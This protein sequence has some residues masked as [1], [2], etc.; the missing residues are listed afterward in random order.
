M[1]GRSMP[2]DV[3]WDADE[4]KRTDKIPELHIWLAGRSWSEFTFP[5]LDEQVP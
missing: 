5:H 2:V 1:D 4:G 3:E